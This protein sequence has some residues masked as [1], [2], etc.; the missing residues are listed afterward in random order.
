MTNIVRERTSIPITGASPPIGHV[1]LL[2]NPVGEIW[3]YISC[4]E[5]PPLSLISRVAK[6]AMSAIFRWHVYDRI[7]FP[8]G[9]KLFHNINGKFCDDYKGEGIF[10]NNVIWRNAKKIQLK[11]DTTLFPLEINPEYFTSNGISAKTIKEYYKDTHNIDLVSDKLFC[12]IWELLHS[13]KFEDITDTL[14]CPKPY[15]GA[16]H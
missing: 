8:N 15:F 4:R 16:R 7:A 1:I 6:V 12:S 2:T 10:F 13:D 11:T 14:Q 3:D 9:T 5:M